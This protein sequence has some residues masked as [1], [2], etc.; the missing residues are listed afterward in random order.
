MKKY[1]FRAELTIE[2]PDDIA[3]RRWALV[4]YSAIVSLL[5]NS[6]VVGK[7]ELT[8]H[9]IYPNKQPRPIRVDSEETCESG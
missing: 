2:L 6:G 1:R 4:A 8:L 5:R 7:P 3:A 9:E